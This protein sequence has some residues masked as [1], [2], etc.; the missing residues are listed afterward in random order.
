MFGSFSL[1]SGAGMLRTSIV[2]SCNPELFLRIHYDFDE[3]ILGE[4]FVEDCLDVL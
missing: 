1:L 2:F 4:D 3:V